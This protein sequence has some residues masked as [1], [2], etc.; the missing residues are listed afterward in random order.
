MG[1]R[2]PEPRVLAFGDA[3]VLVELSTTVDLAV[4]RRAHRLTRNLSRQL[5]GQAAWGRPVAGIAS[6]IVPFDLLTIE[7]TR[8]RATI[9]RLVAATGHGEAGD[10][11]P[12]GGSEVASAASGT[13]VGP[14]ELAVRYGGVDGPDLDGVADR[15]GLSSAGLVDLHASTIYDVLAIGFL[16][17]FA[18]LGP[19]PDALRLARRD[20]PRTVVPAGSVAIA[21]A[22]TAVYP[23]E[24]PGG[25]HVI[26]RTAAQLWDPTADPPALLGAGRR[27]RFVPEPTQRH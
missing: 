2:D 14:I 4:N 8:A 15:L 5:A 9:E 21:D 12:S 25:W 27:V 17:G 7:P 10:A 6:L 19:L 1:S 3:A 23:T 20:T 24:S 13:P 11:E 26:G 22:M 18:Y 16:P